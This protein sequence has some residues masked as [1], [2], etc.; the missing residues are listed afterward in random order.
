MDM[1]RHE[2]I[3]MNGA[4]MTRR[5]A[6]ETSQVKPTVA[7]SVETRSPVVATLDHVERNSGQL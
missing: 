3:G 6:I 2:H 1:V 5:R 4:A 7:V